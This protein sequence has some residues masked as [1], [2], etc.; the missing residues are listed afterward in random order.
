MKNKNI[1]IALGIVCFVLATSLT[2]QIRTM[3]M[4]DSVVKQNFAN[5]E[6]KDN[7]LQWKEKYDKAVKQLEI[8]SKQLETIR[9]NAT[10]NASDSEEKTQKLKQNNVLLGLTNVKGNGIVIE[11]A[12]AKTSSQYADASSL[13]IHD[14]NLREIINELANAGAEA[15]E[16][17][18]QRIV[19]STYIMCAGNVILVNGEKIGSPCVIK[20]IG[21]Q[22]M[23]YGAVERAGG[24]LQLLRLNNLSITVRK[25]NNI[26]IN[27]YNGALTRKYMKDVE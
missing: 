2:L 27:K 13:L 18:G 8:S 23:L 9:A 25:E 20:A 3:T 14:G 26:Q 16:I 5:E 10:T 6:L 1:G 7:L 24:I 19:N 22:E 21:Q 15:I 17:N 4:E 12:D 11:M